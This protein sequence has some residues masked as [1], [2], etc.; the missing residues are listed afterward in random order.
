[1]NTLTCPT[2]AHEIS[3]SNLPV[4]ICVYHKS[5]ITEPRALTAHPYCT[6]QSTQR[7]GTMS[8]S[9]LSNTKWRWWVWMIAANRWIYSP[10]Q[11]AW[12]QDRQP[13]STIVQSLDETLTVTLSWRQHHKHW[14]LVATAWT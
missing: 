2:A 6:A 11:S 3:V 14:L 4:C 9:F 10:N 5:T 13:V 12:S 7:D 1:L 8:I